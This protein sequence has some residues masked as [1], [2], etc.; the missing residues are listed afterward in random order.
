MDENTQAAC[1]PE[2]RD[3]INLGLR[4]YFHENGFTLVEPPIITPASCE[5]TTEL[6]EIDYFGENAYLSQT[7]QF[8]QKQQPWHLGKCI[9]LDPLSGQKNQKQEN[10]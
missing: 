10:I 2:N 1:N 5:G 3:E 8:M 6:F 7:G 9:A 4:E